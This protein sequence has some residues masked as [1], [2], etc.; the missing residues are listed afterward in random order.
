VG[1]GG[2]DL[3]EVEWPIT[4]TDGEKR[5]GSNWAN[6]KYWPWEWHNSQHNGPE[7][8]TTKWQK[9]LKSGFKITLYSHVESKTKPKICPSPEPSKSLL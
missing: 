4:T 9:A 2:I 8:V 3:Q 1:S 5:Q 6:G 7:E